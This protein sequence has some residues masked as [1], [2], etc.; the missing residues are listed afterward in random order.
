MNQVSHSAPDFRKLL[1]IRHSYSFALEAYI[2]NKFQNQV[3]FGTEWIHPREEDIKVMIF[4]WHYFNLMNG[5]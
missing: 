1:V 2:K 5:N 3:A 4:L